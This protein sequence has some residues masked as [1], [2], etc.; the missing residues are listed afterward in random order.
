MKKAVLL[1]CLLLMAAGCAPS[2]EAIQEAIEATAAAAPSVTPTEEPTEELATVTPEPTP[3]EAAIVEPTATAT[4]TT[5]PLGEIDLG[6][7]LIAEGDL[8]EHLDGDF[9][10]YGKTFRFDRGDLARPDNLVSQQFY[11]SEIE[12]LSGGV[13]VYVYEDVTAASQTY[14]AVSTDM[15]GLAGMFSEFRDDVGERAKIEQEGENLYHLAF[16]RCH[17]FVEIFMATPREFDIVTYAQRLDERLA[18]VLCPAS[19]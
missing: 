19:Q 16:L 13:A 14:G 15:T 6:P 3:T 11:N 17:A 5:V 1:L 10:Q 9:V 7:L 4:A 8:P 12:N 18:M 2:E